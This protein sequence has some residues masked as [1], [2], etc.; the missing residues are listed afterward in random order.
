MFELM[1]INIPVSGTNYDTFSDEIIEINLFESDNNIIFEK[2]L[3]PDNEPN[4]IVIEELDNNIDILD[5]ESNNKIKYEI[6]NNTMLIEFDIQYIHVYRV[7][8][9]NVCDEIYNNIISITEEPTNHVDTNG[10]FY[11]VLQKNDINTNETR[12]YINNAEKLVKFLPFIIN[13]I[14][15]TDINTIFVKKSDDVNI[16]SMADMVIDNID[17]SFVENNIYNLSTY[18]R[19]YRDTDFIAVEIYFKT[20]LLN[21]SKDNAILIENNRDFG[22]YNSYKK[23]DIFEYNDFFKWYKKSQEFITL[24]NEIKNYC[25]ETYKI[26]NIF[27]INDINIRD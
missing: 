20:I 19:L 17:I 9:D 25:F 4:N 8:N 12:I 16:S 3:Y 14:N 7:V 6:K 23:S 18:N 21:I 27:F 22:L 15:P 24:K 13:E 10:V 5:E 2:D 11:R 1:A 26:D